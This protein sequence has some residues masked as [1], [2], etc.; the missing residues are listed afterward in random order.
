[1]KS[2]GGRGA[3]SQEE[4]SIDNGNDNYSEVYQDEPSAE[5]KHGLLDG[6]KKFGSSFNDAA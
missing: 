6:F 2:I 5:T 3:S 1:M 4:I